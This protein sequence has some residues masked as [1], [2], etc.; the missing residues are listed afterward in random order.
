[1]AQKPAYYDIPLSVKT[2]RR[3]CDDMALRVSR[4][5]LLLAPY[6]MD[7]IEHQG[8]A[9]SNIHERVVG[10]RW[11]TSGTSILKQ[12]RDHGYIQ[13]EE[14][15]ADR[16]ARTPEGRRTKRQVWLTPQGAERL[17]AR[18]HHSVAS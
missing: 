18:S 1:M 8:D 12:L 17:G 3:F 7:V 9:P 13:I 14:A 16:A 4:P 6:I 11:S 15:P 10:Q 5:S 2:I